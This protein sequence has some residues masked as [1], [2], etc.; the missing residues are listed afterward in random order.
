MI[1]KDN[2]NNNK[3][4]INRTTIVESSGRRH[5]EGG[6]KGEYFQGTSMSLYIQISFW[7]GLYVFQL[8]ELNLQ[9]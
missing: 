3:F 1:Q 5:F 2:A 4:E 7:I 8:A 9:N 6:Q